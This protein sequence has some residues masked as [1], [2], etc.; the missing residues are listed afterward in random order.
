MNTFFS[1]SSAMMWTYR[2][3]IRSMSSLLFLILYIFL[4]SIKFLYFLYT[5]FYNMVAPQ[6]YLLY[7]NKR[8]IPVWKKPTKKNKQENTLHIPIPSH[9]FTGSG[10]EKNNNKKRWE[11]MT[12]EKL[13]AWININAN[14]TY[15]SHMFSICLE[16]LLE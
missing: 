13:N 12:R 15:L 1:A 5:F 6:P 7:L 8:Y 9:W 2:K 11:K 4:S 3:I 14:S 16:I 10:I